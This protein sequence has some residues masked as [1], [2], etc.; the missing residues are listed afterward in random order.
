MESTEARSDRIRIPLFTGLALIAFAANSVICRL[1]LG[2]A[3]IDPASF[4]SIRLASGAI[5]LLFLVGM[6]GERNTTKAAGSWVSAAMLFLYA[7][8]FSF[9]Y[10]RLETGTGALIL[11]GAVQA[12]MILAALSAG[13]RPHLVAWVGILLALVGL[14]CL[15]S[16]GLTAP[17]PAGS[18]LMTLAG[19]SWG[20]YSLRGRGTDNP[21]AATTANFVRCV[22]LV[23]G[24]SLLKLGNL[25]LSA[26]G[27]LLAVLSGGWPREW[28]TLSGIPH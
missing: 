13:E 15:V 5:T 10:M 14:V 17:S 25:D 2:E 27:I 28:D 9:A 18:A 16:P 21:V 26:E 20:V 6:S 19:I 22:P 12:T 23:I 8:A 11:F 7:V 1:A 3:S 24:L 4:S